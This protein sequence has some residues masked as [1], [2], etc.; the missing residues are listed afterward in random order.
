[1]NALASDRDRLF[2]EALTSLGAALERVARGYEADAELRRDLLQEI[3]A[4]LWHSLSKFDGRCSVKT[5]TWRVAHNVGANH[6][7]RQRRVKFVELEDLADEPPQPETKLDLTR[8][9]ERLTQLIHALQ[10]LDR[11]LVLLYLEGVEAAVIADVTGLTASNVATRIHRLKQ[12]LA[13][14]FGG[15]TVS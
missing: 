6:L 3:H 15:R 8:T 9:V 14:R 1:V 11:Q 5:W 13:E 4:T 2:Q 12:R 10:P 7:S